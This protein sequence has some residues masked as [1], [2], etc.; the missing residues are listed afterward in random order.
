MSADLVFNMVAGLLIAA[1]L[2]LIFLPRHRI[3]AVLVQSLLLPCLFACVY[4]WALFVGEPH[5]D[6]SGSR[7]LEAIST[8]FESR[9]AL[10]A[11]WIQLS[12]F[13]LFIGAWQVRDACRLGVSQ[14]MVM[15]CLIVTAI[16]GPIGLAM[17]LLLRTALSGNTKLTP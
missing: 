6:G 10:L 13:A 14:W 8:L 1:W 7:S 12:S 3:T 9:K 17:Y 16:A 15:P 2:L 4:F 11:A 5:N